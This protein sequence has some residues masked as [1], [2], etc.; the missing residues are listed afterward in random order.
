MVPHDDEGL[1]TMAASC[2]RHRWL[3]VLLNASRTEVLVHHSELGP[4]LM[5]S[6]A[7]GSDQVV[8][9]SLDVQASLSRDDPHFSMFMVRHWR[10][11][12]LSVEEQCVSDYFCFCCCF[13]NAWFINSATSPSC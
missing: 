3:S 8:L 13:R 2:L 10:R 9:Q 12:D 1:T 7:D 4:A 6:M 5:Q 11:H